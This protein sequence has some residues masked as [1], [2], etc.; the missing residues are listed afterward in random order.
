MAL[1]ALLCLQAALSLAF[2]LPQ[3]RYSVQ[4]QG[5]L[6]IHER[7]K[8]GLDARIVA[9]FRSTDG[10]G[11]K[12]QTTQHS[13]LVTTAD[14][15]TT[16]V[17]VSAIPLTIQSYGEAGKATYFQMMDDAFIASNGKVYRIPSNGAC[18]ARFASYAITHTEMVA[19][20]QGEML[21]NSQT[22]IQA[23]ANR[24]VAHPAMRLLEPAAR[25]LGEDLGVTG[26]DE[27]ASMLFYASAMRLSELYDNSKR[28]S[29]RVYRHTP[30]FDP[31]F[32]LA[33]SDLDCLDTCPPCPGMNCL[34][35]C[36][37]LCDCW[38]FTCGDCCVHEGCLKHDRCCGKHG[39]YSWPCL[40]P[41]GLSCNSFTCRG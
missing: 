12:F 40:F 29:T 6:T 13:L 26:T 39:F 1:F 28:F 35:M 15:Q 33:Q 21:E 5:T 22:A 4:P 17:N 32:A 11:I 36:G 8:R 25:A 31:F 37:R 20:L 18:K 24:L 10:D 27:P 14:E 9:L 34:G 23:S 38:W 19:D 30:R 2:S 7:Q 41:V 3:T 16:L